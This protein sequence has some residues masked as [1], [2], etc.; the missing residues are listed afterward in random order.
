MHIHN[1]LETFGDLLD[2]RIGRNVF[3]TEDS[4]RYTFFAAL[5]RESALQPADIVL[6]Y[7]HPAISRAQVDTWIPPENGREGLAVEFKYDRKIP[8]DKNAPRTQNEFVRLAV[9][10]KYDRKIPSDK[11]APRTQKAG[12]I[13][14]DLYR[15]GRIPSNMQRLLIYVAGAEMTAYFKN[16]SNGLVDFFGLPK[17]NSMLIDSAFLA[18]RSATFVKS[19]GEVPNIKAVTLYSRSLPKNHE[20]R[21][22]EVHDAAS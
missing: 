21:V 10:F 17:G 5:L 18:E 8:S 1:A 22:F 6:E 16:P 2:T 20:L 15:L 4:I 11:N 19:A 9:E 7:R 14:H 13:F 3:T 12:K